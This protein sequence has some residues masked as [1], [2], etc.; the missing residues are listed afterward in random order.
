[1]KRLILTTLL[2]AAAACGRRETVMEDKV[3]VTFE[4]AG[5]ALP[6]SRSVVGA[7]E[8]E[9]NSLLMLFYENGSLLPEL[10]VS[11]TLD[12][13]NQA[14]ATV[15][16]DIGHDYEVIAFAN[17][18]L[19]EHPQDIAQAM[20]LCYTCDGVGSWTAEGI[21]MSA[22]KSLHA[23]Y[24]MP[25]VRFALVRLASRVDL[26]I[27]TSGL[28]HGS[29]SFSS[30][31]V[32]QMNR[33]CP[34]FSEGSASTATGVC[35]GDLAS[36]TDLAGINASGA[37][38]STSFYLLENMQGNILGGN[39]NPD[40][41]IPDRVAAAG[42]DPGL[43]T[44]LE[45]AGAYTDRSGY[46]TSGDVRAHLFLGSDAVSNFD[47]A[48]N[49]RYTVSLTI[50][51]NGCLRT[52]WKIDGNLDDSRVLRFT[53]PEL[54][55]G[56]NASVA[57]PLQTNLSL[58]EGDY[59]YSVAGD[60]QFFTVTPSGTGFTVRSTSTV[61][62]GQS[63]VITVRS[64]DGALT[65]SC[66]VTASF[67]ET[68][69]IVVDWEGDLYVGQ[70]GNLH[71]VSIDGNVNPSRISVRTSSHYSRVEGSGYDWKIY[72]LMPGEEVLTAYVGAVVYGYIGVHYTLPDVRFVSE[73]IVLPPDGSDMECGPYFYRTDGTRL[74]KS[75]FDPELY[76]SI[77]AMDVERRHWFYQAGRYW[78]ECGSAGN[79]AVVMTEGE[80]AADPR[81]FRITDRPFLGRT[82]W[83]NYDFS[84]GAVELETI[85]A[86]FPNTDV[87]S[88]RIKAYLY[89]VAPD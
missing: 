55:V 31:A 41:K 15:T 69:K 44:Y 30:I 42:G 12:G 66:T 20:S 57:V 2:L 83:E 63:I 8:D 49:R 26:I 16:L 4:F 46:L 64:W 71:I 72:A 53:S 35:D 62:S 67:Q 34:Y 1:M 84:G 75:D 58:S 40:Y 52:D 86:E 82:I 9:I 17:V 74:Y 14:S 33:C 73:E 81:S 60:T 79:P 23:R 54:T 88:M 3:Q 70:S 45:I 22:Y 29:L 18:S 36:A 27:N 59:S 21:P 13:G 50:T 47:L 32:R 78:G 10:T 11:R 89:T 28:R 7:A 39:G 68:P 85:E 56:K 37:G 87:F 48:R 5:A 6:A 76:G 24:A 25:A 38:Y 19:H 65:S 43:C 51:D 77:L 61:T 80:Q